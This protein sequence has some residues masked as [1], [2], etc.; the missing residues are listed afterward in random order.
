MSSDPN[1]R[2]ALEIASR[3]LHKKSNSWS[4]Y[5]TYPPEIVMAS[6]RLAI[7]LELL[8]RAD[9]TQEEALSALKD[10]LNG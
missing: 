2:R 8:A 6:K 4:K 7:Q 1:N 10:I 5:D 3:V 9:L